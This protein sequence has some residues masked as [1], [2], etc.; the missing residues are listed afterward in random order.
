LT[1]TFTNENK[2][3]HSIPVIIDTL[4]GISFPEVKVSVSRNSEEYSLYPDSSPIVSPIYTS[5]KSEETNPI[6]PFPPHIYFPSPNGLFPE[7]PSPHLEVVERSPLQSLEVFENPLLAPEVHLLDFQWLVLV[8]PEV[9]EQVDKVKD[10][11]HLLEYF[12]R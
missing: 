2:I 1:D 10:K 6:F 3:S 11:L 8:A 5:C 7:L 9:E 12:P 4:L